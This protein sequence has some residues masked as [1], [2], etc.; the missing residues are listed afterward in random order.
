[1]C[2]WAKRGGPIRIGFADGSVQAVPAT[3]PPTEGA[4][5]EAT[6]LPPA[7]LERLQEAGTD[8]IG[9]V[10]GLPSR[11]CFAVTLPAAAAPPPG[12]RNRRLARA[13]ALR[14][15]AEPFLP[16]DVEDLAVGQ[17]GRVR[18]WT[19]PCRRRCS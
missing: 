14:F 9:L 7:V 15:R 19:H 2:C 3:G 11:R 1:M 4:G 17:H 5:T 16:V 6:A 12:W 8:R 13:R 18:G 10:L